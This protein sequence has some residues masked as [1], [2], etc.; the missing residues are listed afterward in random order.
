MNNIKQILYKDEFN[1]IAQNFYDDM[2][3]TW[4]PSYNELL[5][6][7]L[8]YIPRIKGS[9]I[10]ELGC[11]SGNITKLLCDICNDITVVDL[12]EEMLKLCK[13]KCSPYLT[14]ICEDMTNV[15][16]EKNSFDTIVSSIAIHHLSNDQ[17]QKLFLK[18]YTWLKPGGIFVITDVMT[19]ENKY[20]DTIASNHYN[21]YITKQ[22]ANKRHIKQLTEHRR[23]YDI[24]ASR[25]E[26]FRWLSDCNFASI[27][28]TWINHFFTTIVCRK[29]VS[30]YSEVA[31]KKI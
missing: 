5:S 4:I 12:S 31:L 27:N 13:L 10:L 3:Y 28:Y 7:T 1:E 14:I 8:R 24:V 22:G 11:G 29:I 25:K 20:M 9:K 21:D 26:H 6:N 2:I 19:T 23:K 15:N 18:I 16:F 30:K 17:K